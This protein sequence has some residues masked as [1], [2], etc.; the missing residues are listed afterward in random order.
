MENKYKIKS[1]KDLTL[2][3]DNSTWKSVFK[4]IFYNIQD[5]SLIWFQYRLIHRVLGTKDLLCK[6][7]LEDANI[8]RICQC[9]TESLMH[10]F[11]HCSH[12]V[13]YLWTSLESWI[14]SST[15]KRLIF[16]QEDIILGHLYNDNNYC[17]V[18]TIIAVTKSYIFSSTV[19]GAINAL[20]HKLIND[21]SIW[22]WLPYRNLF[23]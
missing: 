20:K 7:S 10:L 3:I 17:P 18:N 11:L 21:K 12:V 9:E 14:Y 8:C 2:N 13:N 19:H 4:Q 23:V 1:N 6:M 22:Q 15:C 16:S 5:N